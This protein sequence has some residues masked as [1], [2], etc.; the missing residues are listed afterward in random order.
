MHSF[1]LNA[2]IVKRMFE[3]LQSELFQVFNVNLLYP[4]VYSL[5][6]LE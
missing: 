4:N 3:W 1:E 5:D 6:I 2:H